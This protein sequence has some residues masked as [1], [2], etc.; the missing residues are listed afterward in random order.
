MTCNGTTVYHCNTFNFC[1]SLGLL[2][3]KDTLTLHFF[4]LY[5][6]YINVITIMK[7]HIKCNFSSDRVKPQIWFSKRDPFFSM[8][9][10]LKF[11]ICY[12]YMPLIQLYSTTKNDQLGND[13]PFFTFFFLLSDIL[14]HKDTYSYIVKL[15]SV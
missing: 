4:V 11:I 14:T 1:T 2:N 12:N 5:L 15:A 7:K 3:L 10:C 6:C 13:I 9:S 8:L